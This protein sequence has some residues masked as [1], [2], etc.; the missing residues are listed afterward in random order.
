MSEV[1]GCATAH[2]SFAA[3]QSIDTECQGDDVCK[4]WW[5]EQVRETIL[6]DASYPFRMD[7]IILHF[8]ASPYI[9]CDKATNHQHANSP[10]RRLLWHSECECERR[11]TC[12]NTDSSLHRDSET[13]HIVNVVPV[14]ERFACGSAEAA[15]PRS[16]P[17]SLCAAR[18]ALG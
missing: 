15:P 11:F 4:L 9:G 17:Q 3:A 14:P 5:G 10:Y 1:P 16:S 6:P 7:G 2:C 8:G 12:S 13:R 18:N